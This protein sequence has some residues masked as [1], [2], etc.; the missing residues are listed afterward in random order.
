MAVEKEMKDGG[1]PRWWSRPG[2][3]YE[4]WTRKKQPLMRSTVFPD[5]TEQSMVEGL[6]KQCG[7]QEEGKEQPG[8]RLAE[9]T[10]DAY[11]A[12]ISDCCEAGKGCCT[13]RI[14][15]AEPDFGTEKSLLETVILEADHEIFYPKFHCEL[16][17]IEYYWEALKKYDAGGTIYPRTLQ[18]LIFGTGRDYL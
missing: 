4:S 2:K 18:V 13:R 9:G 12:H 6:K 5:G 14:L 16:N 7:R 8:E 15:K 3:P 11:G 1:M 10:T 17:Y